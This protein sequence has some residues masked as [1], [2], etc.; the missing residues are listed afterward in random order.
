MR[1]SGFSSLF[2]AIAVFFSTLSATCAE[3]YSGSLG[4]ERKNPEILTNLRRKRLTFKTFRANDRRWKFLIEPFSVHQDGP[5]KIAIPG[6][7]FSI[8]IENFEPGLKISIEVEFFRS[9]GPLGKREKGG[10][11]QAMF[12]HRNFNS[13]SWPKLLL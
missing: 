12:G 3:K 6:L 5:A 13:P 11:K 7:K 4:K 8:E 1:I 9:Q 2:S 10:C